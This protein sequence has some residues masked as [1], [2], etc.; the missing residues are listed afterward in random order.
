VNV[1]VLRVLSILLVALLTGAA[2]AFC[3]IIAFVGLV[4]PH[5]IRMIIGPAHRGL[6][7]ASA[8]GGG[9]LMLFADLV[10]RTLIGGADLPIGMLTSLIGGPFFFFLLFRAR[11][12]SG[13]W[14]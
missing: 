14:A 12:R 2:V 4:I 9:A 6:I 7:V 5:V 13:G 11:R 8:F 3:G 10:A 1:E